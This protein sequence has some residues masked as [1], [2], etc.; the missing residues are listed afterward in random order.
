MT[1]PP[2]T[3]QLLTAE[4]TVD[5]AQDLG[6]MSAESLLRHVAF[7]RSGKMNGYVR[8]EKPTLAGLY[9]QVNKQVSLCIKTMR[10]TLRQ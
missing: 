5:Y 10:R 2:T 7:A 9:R 6:Q 1:M 4:G 8:D 3:A